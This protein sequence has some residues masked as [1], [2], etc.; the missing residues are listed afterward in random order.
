MIIDGKKIA[1]EVVVELGES[2][3]GRTLGVVMNE[4]DAATESFVKIKERIAQRLGVV[5]QRFSPAQLQEAIACDGALVQLPI[6]NADA[7]L[8]QIPAEKDVDNLPMAP[9]AAA[10]L[11]ILKRSDVSLSGKKAVV[12][13][14]GRLVGKPTAIML[15][16]Q[17]AEV[18][19]VSLEQGSLE[20]LK[21]ADVV[22][23][24]AGSPGLIKPEMVKE[25]VILIDAGTSES[26]GKLVGD[27]D[28]RCADVA[29][30]FTPVPGGVGPVAVAMLFKN[31][32]ILTKK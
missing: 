3:V 6:E 23:S 2:L 19:I 18:H 11:E 7:L 5:L 15:R 10:V 14:E 22:V 17:G 30:I 9:V 1:E 29:R 32:A 13:G 21:D 16:E 12:V 4:G 8:A 28:P 24:G 25:G 31:L 26:A 27:C 20:M